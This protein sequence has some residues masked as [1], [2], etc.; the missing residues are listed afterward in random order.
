MPPFSN[1][2]T[3]SKSANP[4]TERNTD[5]PSGSEKVEDPLHHHLL[6]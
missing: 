3:G 6:S 5:E 1:A 2:N 4:D